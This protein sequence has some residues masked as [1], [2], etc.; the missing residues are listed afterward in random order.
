M[1]KN[2]VQS[3]RENLLKLL[4]LRCIFPFDLNGKGNIARCMLEIEG[5]KSFVF[6]DTSEDV[7][8]KLLDPKSEKEVQ[9]DLILYVLEV[10]FS[11]KKICD[12][13][14]IGIFLIF[15]PYSFRR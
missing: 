1:E 8:V 10:K 2:N 15:L 9:Y 13:I 7:V 3:F 5:S 6:E 14:G 4:Q 11:T 12:R